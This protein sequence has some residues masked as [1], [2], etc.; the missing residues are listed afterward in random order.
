[1]DRRVAYIVSLAIATGL[2]WL[3]LGPIAGIVVIAA[4]LLLLVLYS[5]RFFRAYFG[6]SEPNAGSDPVSEPQQQRIGYVGRPG[7]SANLSDARF[8]AELDTAIDNSGEVDARNARF[9]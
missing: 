5:Q 7:S 8:G 1:M 2:G 3:S 9:D 4:G 6:F